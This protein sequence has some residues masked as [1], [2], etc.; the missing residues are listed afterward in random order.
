MSKF[1]EKEVID[2]LD[3][4]ISNNKWRRI[5]NKEPLQI[6]GNKSLDNNVSNIIKEWCEV[7]DDCFIRKTVQTVTR[8]KNYQQF[9]ELH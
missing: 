3:I 1:L 6:R 9:K 5:R 8:T 4:T 2:L 7:I